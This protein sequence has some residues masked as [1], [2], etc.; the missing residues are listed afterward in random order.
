MSLVAVVDRVGDQPGEMPQTQV[1]P[2]GTPQDTAF[3]AYS[4]P[5][6]LQI[7][8]ALRSST[9]I[10]PWLTPVVRLSSADPAKLLE[11]LRRS[12]RN[13]S[14]RRSWRFP[15]TCCWNWRAV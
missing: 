3:G 2:V 1:I 11:R 15:K 6:A 9:K 8:L 12:N 7:L 13:C 4:R 10:P 5:L 14:S